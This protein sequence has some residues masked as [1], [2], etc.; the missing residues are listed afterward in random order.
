MATIDHAY[1]EYLRASEPAAWAYGVAHA[2]E[3]LG[4]GWAAHRLAA[5]AVAERATDDVTRAHWSGYAAGIVRHGP[6]RLIT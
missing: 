4:D 2:R 3:D 5:I 1:A 6:G